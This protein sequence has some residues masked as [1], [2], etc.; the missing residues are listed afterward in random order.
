APSPAGD[1]AETAPSAFI[2]RTVAI[3][4]ADPAMAALLLE[5]VQAEGIRVVVESDGPRILRHALSE[6]PALLIVDEGL[7]GI[8]GPA[9]VKAIR[10]SGVAAAEEVPIIVISERDDPAA[11]R[12]ADAATEWL[13]KPFS[14]SYARTRIRAALLRTPCRWSKPV[15]PADEDRR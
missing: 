15:I 7:P 11:G 8:G 14:M 1:S 12:T 5:A 6:L 10:G 13:A 2:D 4:T 3:G 9:M